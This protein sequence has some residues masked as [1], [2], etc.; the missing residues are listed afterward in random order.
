MRRRTGG[1]VVRGRERRRPARPLSE[2]EAGSRR[3]VEPAHTG[4]W[5]RLTPAHT[6]SSPSA[7]SLA[8][9]ASRRTKRNHMNS[10]KPAKANHSSV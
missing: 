2:G 7:W 3:A 4:P 1:T 9:S 10:T 6:G 5:N 8:A